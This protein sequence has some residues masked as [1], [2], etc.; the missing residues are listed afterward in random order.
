MS[1]YLNEDMVINYLKK[2][3]KEKNISVKLDSY[4][5]YDDGDIVI[6]FHNT[7]EAI[8]YR[9]TTKFNIILSYYR[10]LKI[11]SLYEH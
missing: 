3:E 6:D 10:M 11:Q 1:E 7:V 2:I 4:K 9:D 8:Y 5:V